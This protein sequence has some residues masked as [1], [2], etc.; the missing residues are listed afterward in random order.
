MVPAK[1]STDIKAKNSKSNSFS[2]NFHKVGKIGI[3]DFL[4][5]LTMSTKVFRYLLW[6]SLQDQEI[7]LI[8]FFDPTAFR[9]SS[10]T[11]KI[12]KL[13]K[14]SHFLFY[15]LNLWTYPQLTHLLH[16]LQFSYNQRSPILNF[17]Q[18]FQSTWKQGIFIFWRYK[19]F[20]KSK[21]ILKLSNALN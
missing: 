19:V 9:A 2:N 18:M 14:S 12:L 5:H 16:F 4:H 1:K 10:W 21:R 3:P 7:S 15:V 20:W 17:F 13:F 6:S 11:N 8:C